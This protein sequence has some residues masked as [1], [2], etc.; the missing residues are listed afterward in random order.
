MDKI[1]KVDPAPNRFQVVAVIS[2]YNEA[3]VIGYCLSRL[4]DD[5]ID[6][7]LMDN[8]SQD[9]TYKIAESFLGKGLIG[10]EKFPPGGRTSGHQLHKR[11]SHK[12]MLFKGFKKANWLMHC[13]A[14]EFRESP[15]PGVSLKDAIY[16]VDRCGYTCIDY[17]VVN[18]RT[19]DNLFIDGSDFVEHFNYYEFG[20]HEGYFRQMKTWKNYTFYLHITPKFFQNTVFSL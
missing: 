20:K 17:T 9:D 2:A 6:V 18:F 7:Y 15:W 13:D 3:D 8:W 11:L 12:E 4:I 19:T 5:G 16:F 14:D 1:F 10:L